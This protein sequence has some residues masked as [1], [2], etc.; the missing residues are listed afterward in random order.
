MGLL[1]FHLVCGL[2]SCRLCMESNYVPLHSDEA[3]KKEEKE[4]FWLKMELL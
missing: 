2:Q 1:N 4:N 3:E